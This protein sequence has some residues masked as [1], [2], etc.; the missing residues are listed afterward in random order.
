[1]KINFSTKPSEHVYFVP[2]DYVQE[3]ITAL[4]QKPV[5][6][7]AYHIT[8]DSPMTT[9]QIEETVCGVLRLDDVSVEIK[10]DAGAVDT[11]LMARFVG[12]LFPYFSS[13]IIFD[14]T[15]VRKVLGDK[16]LDWDYGQKG[17]ETLIRSYYKDHFPDVQWIQTLAEEP[18]Q[19]A[20]RR[21]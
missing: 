3:A 11:K 20:P 17:L 7:T 5:T 1:M 9:R 19:R 14:Q 18:V 15:N 10:E 4:F 16:I 21:G 12:D 2:I 13:D 8:G 6:N